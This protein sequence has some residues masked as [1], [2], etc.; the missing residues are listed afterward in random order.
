MAPKALDNLK[1]LEFAREVSGPYCGKL[2]ADLGAEVVKVEPPEGDP[3][4]SFGAFPDDTAHPEKSALF[5][6]LNT[7]KKG[8]TLDLKRDDQ[9]KR[10][11]ELVRWADILI[12]NHSPEVLEKHGFVWDQLQQLNPSADIYLYH[13]LRANRAEVKGKGRRIDRFSRRGPGQSPAGPLRG[14]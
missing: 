7:N 1:V 10:F 12:D 14:Y 2:F 13:P 11:G 6:Y 5:L 4:R 8:V 9:R 3:S